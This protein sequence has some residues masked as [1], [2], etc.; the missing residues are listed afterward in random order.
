MHGS[1][2]T[3]TPRT[4][5][6][7]RLRVS[8]LAGSPTHGRLLAGG[9]SIPCRLGSGGIV[10]FKREGDGGTPVGRFRLLSLLVRQDR[11]FA[12]AS[13]LPRRN[14]RPADSWCDA[15]ECGSYNRFGAQPFNAS[16][17]RLWRN[18]AIYD[19]L[20]VLD[21]NVMPRVKGRGSAIFFHLCATPGKPTAGCVA[22][23]AADMRRL[24]P[25]LSRHAVMII[26]R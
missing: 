5:P 12:P 15:P 26:Q 17:E 9:T 1:K 22:I 8:G 21:Y 6:L 20:A 24:L 2:V 19:R 10:R 14:I 23:S 11:G 4:I 3:A 25:R 13:R 18:D 16:H 7:T